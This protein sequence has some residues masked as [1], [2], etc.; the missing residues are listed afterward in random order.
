M[1]DLVLTKRFFLMI[2][3]FINFFEN[4][5][6]KILVLGSFYKM[7]MKFRSKYNN[8]WLS[9]RINFVKKIAPAKLRLVFLL[10][11]QAS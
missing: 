9:T 1:G 10:N 7:L 5:F 4:I 11:F 2:I 8:A 3:F 6:L